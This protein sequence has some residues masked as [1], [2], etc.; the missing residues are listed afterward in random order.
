MRTT[1]ATA[2]PPRAIGSWSL[3]WGR[4]TFVAFSILVGLLAL[5]VI[6][7]FFIDEP[8]RRNMEARLNGAMQGYTVEVPELAF[9]PVG[10]SV[11]LGG[12][13]VRQ[14]ANPKIPVVQIEALAASVHWRALLHLRLVA[15]FELTKPRFHINRAQLQA[16]ARD[17]VPVQDKGWQQALE[18][19]YPLKINEFRVT[20]GSLT[21]VE[22][23]PDDALK[24][25]SINV[26]ATNIRN[27]RSPE[28]TYPSPYHFDA[29]IF[30][31]GRLAVDGHANF[32]AEP[33]PTTRGRIELRE[34]PL[35]QLKPVSTL[36]NVYVSSGILSATGAFE[37]AADAQT[38]HLED[39]VVDRLAVDY[40]HA[41]ET[42]AAE[43]RRGEAVQAAAQ[44]TAE[45]PTADVRID[46][47]RLRDAALG[48]VNTAT[49]PE[50]RVYI[51]DTDLELRHLSNQPDAGPAHATMTGRFM[52]SGDMRVEATFL[53]RAKRP[54]LTL[55]LQ[56][57]Q[58]ELRR[59]NDLL[60]AYG[61]FDVIAG[62]FSFYT[63]LNVKDGAITG[64]VK[65]LF[66]DI[67]V[68]DRRQDRD[69]PILHQVY[70]G[71]VGGVSRL[72]ENRRADV[73]TRTD[74]RG[75]TDQP[76]IS[77]LQLIVNLIRNAFFQSI[78]PGFEEAIRNKP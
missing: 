68:Y 39:V 46:R 52:G 8:L 7:S 10:F 5:L 21:Y 47:I 17:E 3:R 41:A 20:D 37:Y 30:E 76:E 49:D 66:T 6:A 55:A 34:V 38:V 65:P 48:Y 23:S 74:V 27:V 58:T 35:Q 25:T 75:P 2:H 53:P 29:V 63:E 45:H 28:G 42:A 59:M 13:T 62:A 71:L 56:I 54:E 72:L 18:E 78:L 31:R 60:R 40:V 73:A 16:E 36:A 67:D 15:D 9:H 57:D 14:D 12:L 61:N 51:S 50:Y 70:E 77:T 24:V 26:L 33:E 43:Q 19:I 64:Y 44:E 1:T 22:R 69:K 11:T 4:R 32:L